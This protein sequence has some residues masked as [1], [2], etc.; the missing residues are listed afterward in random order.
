MPHQRISPAPPSEGSFQSENTREPGP[1][2]NSTRECL[3]QS[4][5]A[6]FPPIN[7]KFILH[8][9]VFHQGMHQLTRECLGLFS[10][11]KFLPAPRDRIPHLFSTRAKP[12]N[13]DRTFH[14]SAQSP[15]HQLQSCA[16]DMVPVH[17]HAVQSNPPMHYGEVAMG[18]WT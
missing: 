3:S 6:S 15:L 2:L 7:S 10:S 9:R 1:L 8:R 13:N 17:F 16:N 11:T 14:C 12:S 18:I 5:R 4:T